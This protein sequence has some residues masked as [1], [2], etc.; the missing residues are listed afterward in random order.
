MDFGVHTRDYLEV[1]M[2]K[3]DLI[4]AAMRRDIATGA[5]PVGARLPSEAALAQ[6]YE[7]APLTMRQALAKLADEGLIDKRHGV[8]SFVLRR[9]AVRRLAMDRYRVD[10]TATPQKPATSFTRDQGIQWSEYRLDRDYTQVSADADLAEMLGVEPG[11]PLLRRHFVFY[12]SGN[13]SQIS[14]NYLPWDLVD[15]T[16][17]DDPEKEPWPGGT[18]AQ[19]RHLGHP[20]NR[21]EEAVAARMP[22]PDEAETLRMASGVPVQTIRRKLISGDLVVEAC[23]EIVIPADRVV[24][25]YAIDV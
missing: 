9:P 10:Q 13:P 15:G 20:I 8:G 2:A 23:R 1:P 25:D 11:T 18:L 12:A 16:G 19:A 24:L 17:V 21:V 7:A 6:Q 14:T 22:T 3:A 5:H 4:A